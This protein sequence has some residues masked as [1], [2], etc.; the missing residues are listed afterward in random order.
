MMQTGRQLRQNPSHESGGFGD[1]IEAHG[2]PRRHIALGADG[3]L[4]RELTIGITRQI[5]AQIKR[6]AARTPCKPGQAQFRRQ[7]RRDDARSHEPVAQSRVFL[8]DRTQCFDLRHNRFDGF[9]QQ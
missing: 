1:F 5:A 9:T 7:R 6:L 4:G 3:L 8:I 2:D